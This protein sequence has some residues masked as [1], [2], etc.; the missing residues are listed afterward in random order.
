MKVREHLVTALRDTVVYDAYHKIQGERAIRRWKDQGR[1]VPPPRALKRRTLLS[2][3]RK[4]NLRILI[5]TGTFRGDMVY[6]LRGA[7]EKIVS[8]ELDSRLYGEACRRLA[9]AAH[10]QLLCGDSAVLLRS[11][12]E[13]IR[14]PALF[15][16]DG[17]YSGPGTA[18]SQQ[19]SPILA[20]MSSILSHVVR[21]HIILIDDAREFVGR[22]GY[23]TIARLTTIATSL[24]SMVSVNVADDMIRIVS[25]PN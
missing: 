24:N 7:F 9:S 10:V 2:Y 17:H 16:L 23:P 6:A 20:E 18:R 15:W 21:N 1:P 12:L 25:T 3:R 22:D 11:V 4:Y 14:E 19:D 13:S 8:I 5:E